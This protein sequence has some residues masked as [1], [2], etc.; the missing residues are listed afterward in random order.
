MFLHLLKVY[1]HSALC[2]CFE[3]INSFSCLSFSLLENRFIFPVFFFYLFFIYFLRFWFLWILFFLKRCC[4]L[5]K[6]N[7]K[8]EQQRKN[9]QS[10]LVFFGWR[11]FFWVIFFHCF[12]GLLFYHLFIA[13][14]NR[15]KECYIAWCLHLMCCLFFMGGFFFWLFLKVTLFTLVIN[16]LWGTQK[17]I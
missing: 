3:W 11:L 5:G 10:F 2:L 14:S 17:K 6:L 7:S 8:I 1:F 9:R 4:L 15:S 12:L 13:M 16:E